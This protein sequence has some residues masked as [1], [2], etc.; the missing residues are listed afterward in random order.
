[1]HIK[2][3]LGLQGM[4]SFPGQPGH[5]QEVT[6]AKAS[7]ACWFEGL[8]AVSSTCRCDTPLLL[9]P[10]CVKLMPRYCLALF[11]SKY[12]STASYKTPFT[13]KATAF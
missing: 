13:S 11:M 3:E 1:M 9:A 8:A 2:A 5:G 6:L 10:I 4:A 7:R 12:L